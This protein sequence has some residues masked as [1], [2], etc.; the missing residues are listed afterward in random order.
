M[1]RHV[2]VTELNYAVI[3]FGDPCPHG[4]DTTARRI[5][6][7]TAETLS[8]GRCEPSPKPWASRAAAWIGVARAGNTLHYGLGPRG[9]RQDDSPARRAEG[10][11]RILARRAIG[12]RGSTWKGGRETTGGGSPGRGKQIGDPARCRGE[13][14]PFPRSRRL[15]GTCRLCWKRGGLAG[16]IPEALCGEAPKGQPV[17]RRETSWRSE[18]RPRKVSQGTTDA[19]ETYPTRD[20]RGRPR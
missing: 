2:I 13:A 14:L 20:Q 16:A 7:G 17:I 12:G 1:N 11:S 8:P 4:Q 18:G 3:A 10:H 6:P 19:E 5:G 9:V 15:V